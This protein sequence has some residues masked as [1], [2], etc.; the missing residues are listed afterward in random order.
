MH[1]NE[2]QQRRTHLITLR[3]KVI[4][5]L[6]S[7]AELRTPLPRAM[8]CEERFQVGVPADEQDRAECVPDRLLHV[9]VRR[10]AV[11]ANVKKWDRW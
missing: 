7:N 4:V 2:A 10:L 9:R 8:F 1:R 3:V 5:S 11:D 6:K